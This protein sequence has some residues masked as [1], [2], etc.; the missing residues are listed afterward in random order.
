MTLLVLLGLQLWRWFKK[1][2]HSQWLNQTWF[3]DWQ[4]LL[5]LFGG[6]LFAGF[7]KGRPSTDS[8]QTKR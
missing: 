7:L 8:D 1:D 6:V 5:L 3:Y 4:I 2:E